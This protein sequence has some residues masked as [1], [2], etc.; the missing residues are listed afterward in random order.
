[1]SGVVLNAT[2]NVGSGYKYGGYRYGTY[3][4]SSYRNDDAKK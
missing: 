4:Y 1:M 2:T 3:A